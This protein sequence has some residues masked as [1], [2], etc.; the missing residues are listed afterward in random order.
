MASRIPLL[1]LSALGGQVVIDET[2]GLQHAAWN[3][4]EGNDR[5]AEWMNSQIRPRW[6]E[7]RFIDYTAA[8]CLWDGR[9]PNRRSGGA[10]LPGR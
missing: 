9:R 10:R 4:S 2:T 6:Q 5:A 1:Q 3:F 8:D 7:V